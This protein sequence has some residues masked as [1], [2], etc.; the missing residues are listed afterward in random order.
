MAR[1]KK[2][3]HKVQMT[4]GKR[5]I[6]QQLIQEYDIETA[7]DIQEAIA[8]AFPNTEYQRCLVHQ[9]RNT[10]KYVPDKDRKAFAKDLKTIYNAPTEEEGRKVLDKVTEK[11]EEKCYRKPQCHLPKAEPSK[12]RISKR[13]SS[14]EGSLPFDF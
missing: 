5:Q 8:T 14:L 9:V 13:S 11:W 2:N 7:E 1:E 4:D 6:I 10:L 12:K 3:L